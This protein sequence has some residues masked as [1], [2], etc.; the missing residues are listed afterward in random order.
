MNNISCVICGD[1]T[2]TPSRLL[3]TVNACFAMSSIHFIDSSLNSRIC[4]YSSLKLISD[5]ASKE[6]VFLI[7]NAHSIDLY[8]DSINRFVQIADLSGADMLYSDYYDSINNS[9]SLHP[10]N[11]IHIGCV[12]DD[13][14]LGNIILIRSSVL[15]QAIKKLDSSLRYGALYTLRLDFMSRSSVEHI[16]EPLYT[17]I[18]NSE[19]SSNE[20]LF[21]YVNPANRVVQIE[22]EKIFTDFLTKIGANIRPPFKTLNFNDIFEYEAS[23]IIPVRDRVKTIKDAIDSVM[24]QKCNF[25]F[26][27]IIVDNHSTDGTSEIISKYKSLYNNLIHIIPESNNLGI[28]GCWN[29]G[30]S[31]I[32]CGK[33]AIQL[34]SDDVYNSPFTIQKIVDCFYENSCA[35]VIG[36]YQMM[37]FNNEPIPPGIIDHKE[38]SDENGANNALRIN[39]LGAPRAFY[40][41]ILREIK[42]PNTS[43][44]EDYAIGLR[45][46]K[47][48]K[49]GRILEPIYNCRRWEGNSD[50]NIDISKMNSYNA[51]KDRLRYFEIKSRIK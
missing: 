49:I 37:N 16:P 10:L 50:A 42:L 1:K 3:D 28:G 2:N 44:G 17:V 48:F 29:L 26:N 46:S 9:I 51:Y 19:T 8:S 25:N 4:D 30:V 5:K 7:F 31:N 23:V 13:F 43:Y 40:S 21:E 36:S 11:D 18:A 33:F 20:K 6:Y 32:N 35:M 41:P 47:E 45:I 24:C 39:G 15:K 38:W 34:D 14:E 27:L 12:R 22:M